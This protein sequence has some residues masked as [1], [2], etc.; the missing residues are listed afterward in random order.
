MERAIACRHGAWIIPAALSLGL[1]IICRLLGGLAARQA[2]QHSPDQR[3]HVH[4][5]MFF[6]RGGAIMR[7]V[8]T[9]R[10]RLHTGGDHVG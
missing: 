1:G 4:S 3:R 7:A 9:M 2:L 6:T 8:H 10:L 5:D